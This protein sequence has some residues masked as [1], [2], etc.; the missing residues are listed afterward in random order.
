M[1]LTIINDTNKSVNLHSQHFSWLSFLAS[2]RLNFI[3]SS[4]AVLLTKSFTALTHSYTFNTELL[5]S[6]F[7]LTLTHTRSFV[8]MCCFQSALFFLTC[9]YF[10]NG[11]I[12]ICKNQPMC[13]QYTSPCLWLAR[14]CHSFQMNMLGKPWVTLASWSPVRLNVSS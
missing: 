5:Y 3:S 13:C 4:S 8:C 9:F 6:A 7:S 11:F 1:I 12:F 10:Y 14:C 2:D